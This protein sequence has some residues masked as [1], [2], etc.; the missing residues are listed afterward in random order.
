MADISRRSRILA[1]RDYS[2]ITRT[3]C[4]G[5]I[6]TEGLESRRHDRAPCGRH[7]GAGRRAKAANRQC[8]SSAERVVEQALITVL[9]FGHSLLIGR[10]AFAQAQA[11]SDHGHRARARC[12]PYPFTPRSDAVRQS[13]REVLEEGSA[14]RRSFPSISAGPIFARC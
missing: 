9:C 13:R 5:G 7:R 2:R 11:C 4:H 6:P 3:D 12:A 10:P 8:F 1:G 14:A